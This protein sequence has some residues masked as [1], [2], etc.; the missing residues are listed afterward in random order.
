MPRFEVD[1][2]LNDAIGLPTARLLELNAGAAIE[3]FVVERIDRATK[4]HRF[5]K[6]AAVPL[7]LFDDSVSLCAIYIERHQ[8]CCADS[9]ATTLT[10][11]SGKLGNLFRIGGS[12][13]WKTSIRSLAA[14]VRIEWSQGEYAI[15]A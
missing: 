12:V 9:D 15:A 4:D 10:I 1:L 11:S 8:S 6:V 5:W 7:E 3:K 2:R 13:K 14:I